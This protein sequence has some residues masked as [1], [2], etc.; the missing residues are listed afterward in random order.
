MVV[1][2]ALARAMVLSVGRGNGV[3]TE[4]MWVATLKRTGKMLTFNSSDDLTS[5]DTEGETHY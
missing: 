2:A 3:G 4:W 1:A 5:T